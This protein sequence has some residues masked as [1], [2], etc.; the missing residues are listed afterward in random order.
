MTCEYRT[1]FSLGRVFAVMTALAAVIVM[2]SAITNW[3]ELLAF[4]AQFGLFISP[5]LMIGVPMI[6]SRCLR[7]KV[8]REHIQLEREIMLARVRADAFAG[9]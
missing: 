3:G 6:I 2:V 9:R 8:R 1:R 7:A 4:A 5:L